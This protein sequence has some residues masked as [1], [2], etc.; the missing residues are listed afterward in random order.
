MKCPESYVLPAGVNEF[1]RRVYFNESSV[2]V[3]IHDTSNVT[4]LKIKPSEA[5]LRLNTYVEVEAIATDS[6]SNQNTCKFQVALMRK[7]FLEFQKT[8]NF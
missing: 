2:E 3:V 6:H 8:Y 4:E 5:V 7:S 1:E